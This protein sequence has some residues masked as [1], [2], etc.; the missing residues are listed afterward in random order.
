V[1][2]VEAICAGTPEDYLEARRLIEEYVAWLAADLSYQNYDDELKNL[3][4]MYGP[5]RGAIILLRHGEEYAG[6]VGL[7]EHGEGCCEMKRMYV[8]TC[9]QGKGWGK[10]LMDAFLAKARQLGYK[11]V[12]LDSVRSLSVACALY[13]GSGFVEIPPYRYNP[14]PDAVYMEK[15]L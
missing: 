10:V 6:V 14:A 13:R 8:R 2:K 1:A 11:R 4:I 15:V 3:P 5:P 12:V 7:R 9:H